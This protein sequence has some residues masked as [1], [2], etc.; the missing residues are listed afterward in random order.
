MSS[1]DL[2]HRQPDRGRIDQSNV[3]FEDLTDDLLQLLR[4]LKRFESY[5]ES[6]VATLAIKQ[7]DKLIQNADYF[8]RALIDE[9]L[10]INKA[11]RARER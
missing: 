7:C 6:K 4:D 2:H 3:T 10:K 11:W 1:R 9:R 5:P 8:R